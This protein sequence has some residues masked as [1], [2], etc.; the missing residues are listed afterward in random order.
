LVDLDAVQRNDQLFRFAEGHLVGS[1]S[2]ATPLADTFADVEG[3]ASGG[4]PHL[5]A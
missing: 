4:P 5:A 3:D 2:G 1:G